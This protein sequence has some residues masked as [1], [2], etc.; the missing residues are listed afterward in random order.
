MNR[1]LLMGLLAAPLLLNG[2][3]KSPVSDSAAAP[4]SE[5]AAA[6]TSDSAASLSAPTAIASSP[7][8]ITVQHLLIAFAGAIP[9]PT[10]SK[11]E[12]K[13][14]ADE[15]FA[16]AKAGEDFDA[17]VKSYTDDSPPGIYK[18]A[19]SGVAPESADEYQ[20][21]SMVPAFGNVGFA[22]EVGDYGLAEYDS[23][24][25]PFGWHIIKRI[26]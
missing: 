22:L 21:D 19:N 12:A 7:D 20:R 15:L 17:L 18:M 4:T 14:L 24:A 23:V 25:S 13:T 11:E 1:L 8:H 3:G 2:C 5:S 16:K 26:K 10:R 9:G 6:P